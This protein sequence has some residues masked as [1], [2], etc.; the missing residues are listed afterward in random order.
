MNNIVSIRNHSKGGD[1]GVGDGD[2][3][4]G[5]GGDGGG[6]DGGGDGAGTPIYNSLTQYFSPSPTAGTNNIPPFFFSR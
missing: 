1:G 5:G 4:G 2:G 3:G 6:E